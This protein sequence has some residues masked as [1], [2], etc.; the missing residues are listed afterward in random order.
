MRIARSSRVLVAAA[1]VALAVAA[2]VLAPDPAVWLEA[3]RDVTGWTERNRGLGAGLFLAF[4][5]LGKVTPVPGGVVVMLTAGYL[6][7]P[8]TGPVLA[9]LGSALAAV[10][11]TMLG[12][13]VFPDTIARIKGSRFARF[14]AALERDG[15][16][17]LAAIRILPLVPAWVG[18]LL[19]VAVDIRLRW[20]F[21][22]TLAGVAPLTIVMSGIGS[23]LQ[24]LT[25]AAQF[26]IRLI[27][28]PATLL[29]LFG[30]LLLALLP[31][32]VRR[33]WGR[34]LR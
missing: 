7:G 5:T 2:A 33:R 14:E 25:E 26:D 8:V 27:L 22:A 24:S 34:R 10:G 6:F 1:L 19:P 28:D 20:V 11:V 15:I 31:V 12:R 4:A 23:R 13:W 16:A 3:S 9:S 21:L 30:L 29:P 18:N 32:A 17:Y